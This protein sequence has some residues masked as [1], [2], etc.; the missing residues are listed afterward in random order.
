M[1]RD[2]ACF[3]IYSDISSAALNPERRGQLLGD[4]GL[5]NAGW[6]GKEIIADGF[7]RLTQAARASLIAD[8]SASMAASW[9][10]TTRLSERSRSLSTSASSRETFSAMRQSWR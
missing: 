8:E 7:F 2:T 9:P 6:P 3:S 4:L 10:N 1:R 5:A